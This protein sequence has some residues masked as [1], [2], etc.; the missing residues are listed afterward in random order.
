MKSIVKKIIIFV[1]SDDD[2]G[3]LR[4]VEIFSKKLN[5]KPIIMTN[6]GHFTLGEMGTEE[7]PELLSKIL[8]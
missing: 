2:K 7:F 1:S 5:V 3:I 8:N 6:K 4:S